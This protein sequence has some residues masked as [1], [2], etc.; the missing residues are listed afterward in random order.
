[1][2][3]RSLVLVVY[4]FVAAQ[5]LAEEAERDAAWYERHI[6]PLLAQHCYAC[7]SAQAKVPRS[8][9]R[10]DV[11]EGWLRGGQ[12]GAA[13]VPGQ[14][15][16]SL[17][18]RAVKRTDP[19]LH[20]P[21]RQALTEREVAL[22]EEWIR[23]GAPAPETPTAGSRTV[24]LDQAKKHWAF[25]PLRA[26]AVPRVESAWCRTPIDAFIYEAQ[27]QRGLWPNG[28]AERRRPIRRAYLDLLGL[29]PSPEE[30]AAF[31]SDPD[32]KAYE[33]LI[34]RLLASPD[35][36]E[37]WARHWLDVARFAESHGYEQDY[38]RPHAYHYRDFVIRA[39]DA[40][41]PYDQFVRWQVAGDELAPDEPLALMATGF[42]GAGA[43]PTQLTEAEFEKARYDE[44]DDMVHTIGVAFLGLSL[45]CARCHDHPY[46]A[47]SSEQ[48][49]RLAAY[50]TTTIR[51][52]IELPAP[53][54]QKPVLV[55]VTSEGFKPMKH[56]ADER[57]FPHF[58]AQTYILERGDVNRKKGVAT[59][60]VLPLLVRA[61]TSQERWQ[62]AA[63]AGWT[64]TRYLRAG[65]AHWLTDVEAGAGSLLARVIVNRIW[66]HHFGRGLVATVD[67]FGLRG[68]PPSHPQLLEWLAWDLVEH[69]WR[70][71]RLHKLIMTSAVY[72]QGSSV[73]QERLRLD[74]GNIYVWRFRPR[75]LEAEAIRDS[76]LA[77]GGLLDRTR[78]GPGSLD[79]TMRRR[80]V[81]T[82][83]KR[84]QL[85]PF[86]LL[87]DW[88]EHL[89]SIGR[90][91][92]TT[93]GTQAL[94]LMNHPLVRQCAAGL[95]S[96]LP[97][98]SGVERVQA[99]YQI[100]LARSASASEIQ[101]ALAFIQE[102]TEEYL[103]AQRAEPQAAAWTDFCQAL[104]LSSEFM[105][106]D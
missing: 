28:T 68:E 7:H 81:Y 37:R 12:R 64:R 88:P 19:E 57:G 72:M 92:V 60:S 35:Y 89:V 30:V 34:D 20:M 51:S 50:F 82:F 104:V 44:L 99:A 103:R 40:D 96:R 86:L 73:D 85:S 1:M 87:F 91:S 65:L 27:S 15:E 39:F 54:D 48:Y 101:R 41:M 102:Q 53:K 8:G 71:K 17:L 2:H 59:P 97:R 36:G 45:G 23:R 90:R 16:H 63:P 70:L 56:H 26:V 77:V 22:L 42:L 31:V 10:L 55:Q 11:R 69:G 5:L 49:Y 67:D 13:I 52:E 18:I 75:R 93:T 61:G 98:G 80:A 33:K 74:G 6:R 84:S 4:V 58:Y 106:L 76:L 9:L 29:P 62:R 47:V 43:F 100:A 105:Y 95:A 3:V 21:P 83:V 46:E 24:A 25:Q 66:Y 94:A 32:P 14:P 79:P 38:D 78:Y